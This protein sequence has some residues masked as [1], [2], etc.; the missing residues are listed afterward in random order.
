MSAATTKSIVQSRES[1]YGLEYVGTADE[2]IDAGI[3]TWSQ[4]P[5]RPGMPKSSATFL[6]GLQQPPR[7]RAV[8]DERWM[9]VTLTGKKVT[10]AKGI[11]AIEREQRENQRI[12]AAEAERRSRGIPAIGSAAAGRE[13]A[14]ES[15]VFEVGTHVTVGTTKAT[16]TAGYGLRPVSTPNGTYI[17][18]DGNRFIYRPGYLCRDEEGSE[19]FWVAHEVKTALGQR[20]HLRLVRDRSAAPVTSM[21]PTPDTP[22][23]DWP[24]PIIGNTFMGI[25]T[26]HQ[27]AQA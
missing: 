1:W 4:L 5:G 15:A 3:I 16:V 24:F 7:T 22:P 18:G 21:V 2:L 19:F 17:D 25:A 27:E 11:S 9:R 14:Q 10:V 6:D 20:G 13:M 12:A 26:Q 23:V 8:H